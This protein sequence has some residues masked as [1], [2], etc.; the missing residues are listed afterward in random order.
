MLGAP[1]LASTLWNAYLRFATINPSL[2][3]VILSAVRREPNAVEG[4]RV[5]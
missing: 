5:P 1:G 3:L 2:H 4:P